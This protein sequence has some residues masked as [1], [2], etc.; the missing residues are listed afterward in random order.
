MTILVARSVMTS[1]A[2]DA[3]RRPGPR[4]GRHFGAAPREELTEPCG[5]GYGH[6]STKPPG[7]ADAAASSSTSPSLVRASEYD[8]GPHGV[9]SLA[10]DTPPSESQ[11]TGTP[12]ARIIA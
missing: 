12:A 1:S 8:S 10:I 5:D 9:G 2:A 6:G 4:A 7:G 3:G 11:R